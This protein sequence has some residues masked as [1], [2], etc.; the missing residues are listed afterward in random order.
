VNKPLNGTES[1]TPQVAAFRRRAEEIAQEK[2]AQSPED[3]EVLSREE[4]RKM[5]H[6]LRVREIELEMQNDELRRAQAEIE[7]ERERYFD[8]YDLA[9]VSYCTVSEKGLI[10]EANLT[11]A[12]LLGTARDAL[13][14]QPIT[15]FI[16]KENQDIYYLH[17]KQLFETGEP[18]A[19]E[20]RMVKQDGETFWA[21]LEA[22]VAQD[23][24]GAPISR[25][26]ISDMTERKRAE[27]A[28]RAS[29]TRFRNLAESNII[30]VVVAD[31]VTGQ[32]F[33]ANDEYLRILGRTREELLAGLVNWRSSTPP[34]EL[35]REDARPHNR[36]RDGWVE[37]FDKTY[38]RPGGTRVPVIVGGAFLSDDPQKVIAFVLDMTERKRA[39]E[40]LRQSRE[41]LNRAQEVG[42]IGSW[43]LD[44]CRDVL[45]WS[46][47]NHRIFGV[48]KG[49]PLT[50]E[51]FLEIV[52]PDDRQFVDTQWK[53]GLAGE[54]YDIEHRISVDG[55]VKWVREKA[56]LEFDDGGKLLGG[57]GIT[58]DIT[59][60]KAA[61]EALRQLSQFPGENPNPV[62]RSTLDGEILYANAPARHWLATLGR[63]DDGPLPAPVR[64]AV[65]RAIDQTH[66]LETE[67][68]DPSGLT[69]SIFAVQPPGERY[70]NIY[71]LDITERKKAED[72]LLRSHD[73][74]ETRVAERT[75]ELELRNRE[76]Q[77]FS[78]IASH[79]L[80]EPLRKIQA[81]GGMLE[82]E[83][84]ESLTDSAQDYLSRMTGAAARMQELIKALLAYS[85]VATK[86]NPFER[87]DLK[88]MVEKIV[89]DLDLSIDAKQPV[90][91]VG[92]LPAIDADPVQMSQLLQNLMVNAI[93]YARKGEASVVKISGRK[94]NPAGKKRT[95]CELRV[96]DNGIGFDMRYLD[97]IF[98]PFER[99]HGRAEYEGTGMGLAICRRIVER[100]GGK[101]TAQSRPGEGATFIVTLPMRQTGEP[102]RVT[103]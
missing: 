50:Y 20:L 58:Q 45:T 93:R 4:T 103:D 75:L 34:E 2:A 56:Y 87:V 5:L 100:H 49:T 88:H 61:E 15:R 97:R 69:F 102:R 83:M 43:R 25:V 91:E 96:Q 30:G 67:I 98:L 81:F 54:P 48:S 26:V 27:E 33:D 101:I 79:D 16:L 21:S 46:D 37:A 47:E 77:E 90:V 12:T 19:C 76:L 84:S 29:E 55:L 10:L 1:A 31:P 6:E 53:A 85:R 71:G 59:E 68:T 3:L 51:S 32:V 63:Q 7:A 8:L 60:R 28:L 41:D 44:V 18:Q 73:E 42:H 23:E 57:F 36:Q 70:V 17:R 99:L 62:L 11:A 24:S 52:H 38:I 66:A 94:F 82:Q 39:E 86:A 95:Y 35:A 89:G 74:L 13:L 40:E 72:A 64:T 65:A 22:T 78:A 92:D 80:Q 14:K 9:P